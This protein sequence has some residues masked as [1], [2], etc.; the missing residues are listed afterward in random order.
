MTPLDFEMRG[1]H[2]TPWLDT[3]TR[4]RAMQNMTHQMRRAPP[5]GPVD[6]TSRVSS[7]VSRVV[8]NTYELH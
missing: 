2:E 3:H 1:L 6:V 5:T 8:D 4:L 7:R